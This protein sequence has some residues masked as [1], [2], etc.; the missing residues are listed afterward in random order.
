MGFWEI[1]LLAV[2][3][4]IANGDYHF[5][6]LLENFDEEEDLGENL[7]LLGCGLEVVDPPLFA[8]VLDPL[9]GR[10]PSMAHDWVENGSCI[11][12]LRARV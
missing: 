9:A 4:E 12:L 3:L 6:L 8:P 2:V 1:D 11:G 10:H 7:P 5:G